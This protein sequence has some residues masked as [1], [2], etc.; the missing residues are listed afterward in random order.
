MDFLFVFP[1]EFDKKYSIR[2]KT[3]ALCVALFLRDVDSKHLRTPIIKVLDHP[4]S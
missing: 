4:P 2:K 1:M 3:Q